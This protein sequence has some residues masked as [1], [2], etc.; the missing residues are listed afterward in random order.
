MSNYTKCQKNMKFVEH[1]EKQVLWGTKP[2]GDFQDLSFAF[3]I[4]K[5][6]P[7][8]KIKKG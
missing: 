3:T 6:G 1:F 4:L 8:E 7:L 5:I 2:Y